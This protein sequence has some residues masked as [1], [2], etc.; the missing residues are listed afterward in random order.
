VALVI[1]PLVRRAPV[2]AA[3]EWE[4]CVF[5]D[6]KSG[7][8]PGFSEG[9]AAGLEE[10]HSGGLRGQVRMGGACGEGCVG[11]GEEDLES[12]CCWVVGGRSGD[13]LN[14][15]GVRWFSAGNGWVTREGEGDVLEIQD[16]FP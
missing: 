12:V 15:L 2:C 1:R 10:G 5:G 3:V 6:G 14:F 13:I 11:E 9:G 4:I 16:I 8:T 7:G